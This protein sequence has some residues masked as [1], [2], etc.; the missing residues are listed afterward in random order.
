[1]LNTLW[2]HRYGMEAGHKPSDITFEPNTHLEEMPLDRGETVI[3][4]RITPKQFD[5][6]VTGL[7]SRGRKD[8]GVLWLSSRVITVVHLLE[9]QYRQRLCNAGY[10]PYGGG[11]TPT[12][13]LVSTYL[14]IQLCHQVSL[15]GFGSSRD[16][17]TGQELPYHYFSTVGSRAKG[18]TESHSFET[19]NR[20]M[21]ELM[22]TRALHPPKGHPWFHPSAPQSGNLRF[23][24]Q[25]PG[26]GDSEA[27]TFCYAWSDR[28]SR[29]APERGHP[30]VRPS[31]EQAKLHLDGQDPPPPPR[32][33]RPL[34]EVMA[35]LREQAA[36]REAK[37]MV[38]QILL[39]GG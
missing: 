32:P 4:S 22:S 17:N 5:K 27:N 24:K 38:D 10:G 6:F 7:A 30:R 26:A 34:G 28:R 11:T 29:G 39:S 14:A 19:E 12:S 25:E 36:A 20:L 2:T 8:V 9:A 21:Q 16:A 37:R 3:L 1:M 23:C 18:N 15:Y 13:G 31:Q 33:P 35:E